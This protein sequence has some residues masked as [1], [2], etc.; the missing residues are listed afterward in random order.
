M[1]ET[2]IAVE[3]IN[4]INE[5]MRDRPA[6]KVRQVR[7]MIGELTAVLPE[8]L[9]FA[10]RALTENTPLHNSCLAITIIPVQA[11]CRSCNTPFTLQE[12]T[13]SCPGCGSSNIDVTT[14]N[15]LYIQEI[16]VQ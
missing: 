5:T 2:G 16:E 4:I 11:Q 7:I 12:F 1:H 3:I 9:D 6:T 8:S 15:E 14:G 10:Y 13:F